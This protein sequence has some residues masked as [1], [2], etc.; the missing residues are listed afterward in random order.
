M[1]G[2]GLRELAFVTIFMTVHVE[3]STSLILVTLVDAQ[4]LLFGIIGGCIYLCTGTAR[5]KQVLDTAF[6]T[7]EK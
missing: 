5:K 1:N 3:R 7:M 4:I 6:S 2:F